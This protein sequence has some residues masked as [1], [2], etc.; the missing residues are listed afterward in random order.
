MRCLLGVLWQAGP[1]CCHGYMTV[2]LHASVIS[3]LVNT[4]P[5]TSACQPLPGLG[6]PVSYEHMKE[7]Y[8]I[9]NTVERCNMR[10]M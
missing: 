9:L 4:A 10:G 8:V 3:P 6:W 5:L 7:A 1:A 2:F